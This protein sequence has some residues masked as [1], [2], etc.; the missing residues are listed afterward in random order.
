MTMELLEKL[1]KERDRLIS[2]RGRLEGEIAGLSRAIKLMEQDA[3]IRSHPEA[4]IYP[5]RGAV[6]EAV[7]DVLRDEPFGLTSAE[8]VQALQRAGTPQNPASVRST[9][10]TAANSGELSYDDGRYAAPSNP[11]VTS[12]PEARSEEPRRPVEDRRPSTDQSD[13]DDE[14]PF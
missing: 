2:E 12:S 14:I 7:L 13:L 6:K 8:V 3:G 4:R 5:K 1:R 10:S 11:N 9:L